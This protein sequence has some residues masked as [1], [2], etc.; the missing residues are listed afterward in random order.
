QQATQSYYGSQDDEIPIDEDNE[1]DFGND[2][3]NMDLED[4]SYSKPQLGG[5]GPTMTGDPPKG[6]QKNFVFKLFQMLEDPDARAYIQWGT[7]GREFIVT[8]Q[9]E[10]APMV[11]SKHFKHSNFSSFVRQLNMYDFHKTNRAPRSQRG[12]SQHQ[13]WVFSHPRFQQNRPDLLS[14]IKRKA[15]EGAAPAVQYNEDQ[16][17]VPPRAS[18]SRSLASPPNEPTPSAENLILE[19]QMQNRALHERLQQ[20]EAKVEFLMKAIQPGRQSHLPLERESVPQNVVSPVSHQHTGHG[21][22]VSHFDYGVPSGLGTIGTFP[23]QSAADDLTSPSTESQSPVNQFRP[24]EGPNSF[25]AVGAVAGPSRMQT[26][27]NTTLHNASVSASSSMASGMPG[28]TS[29]YQA[30]Q[31]QSTPVSQPSFFTG[32]GSFNIFNHPGPQQ[33]AGSS[34]ENLSPAISRT[35]AQSQGRISLGSRA[36]PVAMTPAKGASMAAVPPKG[37]PPDTTGGLHR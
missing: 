16:L 17:P 9:E 24:S 4:N 1:Q 19:L 2:M 12:T 11:L 26:V 35:L 37:Q 21:N 34:T 28:G 33:V 3:A 7:G 20:M 18:F 13:H 14:G 8:N 15:N 5:R 6:S 29:S 23:Q 32:F 30:I 25:V 36:N 27:T 10:F 22:P 31:H